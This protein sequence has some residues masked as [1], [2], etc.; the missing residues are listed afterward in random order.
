MDIDYE[1]YL[2]RYKIPLSIFGLILIVL[3]GLFFI[4]KTTAKAEY[5]YNLNAEEIKKVLEDQSSDIVD[6][7]K[8]LVDVGG[9][10]LSPGVIHIQEGS[11]LID[12]ITSAGGF[13]QNADMYYVQRYLNLAIKVEDRQKIYIPSKE[14][15]IKDS[16]WYG[17][18]TSSDVKT[19]KININ[20]ANLDELTSLPGVGEVTAQ[21]I[22][23]G[24]PYKAV[25]SLMEVSGIGDATYKKFEHMIQI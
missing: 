9:Q 11:S 21:K 4:L 7:Q 3:G 25:E 16:S 6:D 19:D 12:A 8:I 18:N 1:D 13:G 14:E 15:T 20:T 22:I 17:S 23:D 2:H 24:R 10:V 5:V